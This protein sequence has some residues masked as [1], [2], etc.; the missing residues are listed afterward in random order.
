[1]PSAPWGGWGPWGTA[2]SAPSTWPATQWPSLRTTVHGEQ[3]KM[4]TVKGERDSECFL[5]GNVSG[6]LDRLV[7]A[8]AFVPVQCFLV[9][10][11]ARD[12]GWNPQAARRLSA[13][14]TT[15][16]A[17]HQDV[18]HF[19]TFLHGW[20]CPASVLPILQ[21]LLKRWLSTLRQALKLH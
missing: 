1:M 7:P 12:P 14:Q 21:P 19:M 15:A 13:H 17:N 18:Q 10:A 6:W 3:T 11:K 4:V 5:K 16:P 8:S 2:R 20:T 9:F